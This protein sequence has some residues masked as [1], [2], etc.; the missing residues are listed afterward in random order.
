MDKYS[1]L[2]AQIE[3]AQ[4]DLDTAQ[5]AFKYRYTVVEPPLFPKG[6]AKPKPM[7][8]G[9]IGFL[10]GFVVSILAA[11]GLDLRRGRFESTWQVERA[12]DL[13]ML[14]EIDVAQLAQH[15]IE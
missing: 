1:A 14:A 2:R 7:L 6:A 10:V 15:K 11:V 9:L 4:I 8:V 5:A 13:P 3:A 12:L